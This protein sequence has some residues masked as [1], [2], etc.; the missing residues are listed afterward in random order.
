MAQMPFASRGFQFHA[1][2]QSWAAVKE[3]TRSYKKLLDKETLL[4]TMFPHEGNLN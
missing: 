4:F 2:A 3:V 1:C